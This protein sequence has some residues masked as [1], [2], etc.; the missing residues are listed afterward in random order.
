MTIGKIIC[1]TIIALSNL[2]HTLLF[3][4][5]TCLTS[6]IL[7]ALKIPGAA[8]YFAIKRIGCL[9]R[10]FLEDLSVL[11]VK[12]IL[13]GIHMTVGLFFNLVVEIACRSS[14]ITNVA[15][16]WL[17]K[18][19]TSELME[20]LVCLWKILL[21]AVRFFLNLVIDAVSLLVDAIMT[22]TKELKQKLTSAF[23]QLMKQWKRWIDF[24]DYLRKYVPEILKE[25]KKHVVLIYN[26]MVDNVSRFVDEVMQAA[27]ELKEMIKLAIDDLIKE[28]V[29]VID[30]IR[31]YI[32]VILEAIS[33]LVNDVMAAVKELLQK[34]TKAFEELMKVMG[35]VLRSIIKNAYVL[36]SIVVEVFWLVAG[37][38]VAKMELAF[39]VILRALAVE[40]F[41]YF[42]LWGFGI[43]SPLMCP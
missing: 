24:L 4:V 2:L 25:M 30:Y 35:D 34:M 8:L 29:A 12:L 6:V 17:F 41:F 39:P 23:D 36:F 5:T 31:E 14:A 43:F 40:E 27:E 19:I 38:L 20:L 18:K 32:P 13:K 7:K 42:S 26:N 21:K 11:V 15:A 16:R 3:C 37:E 22:I 28:L 33:K 9:I 1:C 10:C